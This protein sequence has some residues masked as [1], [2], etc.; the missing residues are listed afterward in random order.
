M[1][2]KCVI[3]SYFVTLTRGKVIGAD[4]SPVSLYVRGIPNVDVHTPGNFRTAS[5]SVAH[6]NCEV[7]STRFYSFLSEGF[8]LNRSFKVY[9]RGVSCL[10]RCDLVGVFGD[11]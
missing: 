2:D 6:G 9:I 10:E 8:T 1:V 4:L 3:V 5:V 11:I 7:L